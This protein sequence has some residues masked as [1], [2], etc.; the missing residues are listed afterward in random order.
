MQSVFLGVYSPHRKEDLLEF[1]NH[2]EDLDDFEFEE[3]TKN[4]RSSDEL[5]RFA[6]LQ[7]KIDLDLDLESCYN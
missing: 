1:A 3:L 5:N 4:W 7:D 2:Y 6:D